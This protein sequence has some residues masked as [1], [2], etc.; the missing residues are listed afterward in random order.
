MAPFFA[1]SMSVSNTVIDLRPST[2]SRPFSA[3]SNFRL[4]GGC[5]PVTKPAPNLPVADLKLSNCYDS[6]FAQKNVKGL[7]SIIMRLYL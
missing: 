5:Q 7:L 4:Q 2:M 3:Q 1:G 6:E